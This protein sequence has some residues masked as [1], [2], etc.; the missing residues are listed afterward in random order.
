M[1][2]ATE[3][4]ILIEERTTI[5]VSKNIVRPDGLIGRKTRELRNRHKSY[6]IWLTGLSGSGKSTIA[7]ELEKNLFA[8][9]CQVM[10]LDGDIVRFGLN[11]DLGFSIE[12]RRE[13]IR[14]I[15]E[16]AKLMMEAG[17]V[18]IC[19]F[20]SPYNDDRNKIR[21]GT[22]EGDFIETYIECPLEEC[23]RRDPKGLYKKARAGQ[24]KNFTGIDDPFEAPVNP[25]IS[26]NT[27]YLTVK[28]SVDQILNYLEQNRYFEDPSKAAI[29]NLR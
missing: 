4:P 25:H 20:I 16:A 11:S 14:R 3:A 10:I 28:E 15:G 19:A 27:K 9:N 17:I 8:R 29:R 5:P 2:E 18:T 1:I 22:Q 26:I 21:K 7:R 6:I 12:D 13:N 23:E 24:I